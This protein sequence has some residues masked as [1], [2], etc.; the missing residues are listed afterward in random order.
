MDQTCSDAR[1]HPGGGGRDLHRAATL[2]DTPKPTVTKLIQALEA[3]VRTKLLNR[4]TRRV[5]VTP[6]G[7]AYYERAVRLLSD[8][9]ELDGSMTSSQA[10]SRGRLRI[11]VSAS[12]AL[13]VIIPPL[14]ASTPDIPT[15]RSTSASPTGRST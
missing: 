7:A 11:D 8:L 12:L 9:D 5:T 13:L 6:D 15:S 2:L 14:P 3:H 4:T 1:L 10:T